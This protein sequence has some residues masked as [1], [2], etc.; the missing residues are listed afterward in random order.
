M[1]LKDTERKELSKLYM[2]K[3]HEALR[4]AKTNKEEF[5]DTSINRA[6]YSMF[7]AAQ[8]ALVTNRVEAVKTHEGVSNVFS[9]VFVKTEKF[10]KEVFKS[11]GHAEQARYSAD[12]NPQKRFSTQDAERFIED[13]EKFVSAV[14]KMI[15]KERQD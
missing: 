10:P 9:D 7:Y 11:L 6:Y 3:A 14:E 8:G 13:T 2:E 1:T 4:A 15:T 5:P 12:Y